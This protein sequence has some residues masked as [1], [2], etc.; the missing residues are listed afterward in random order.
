MCGTS[1]AGPGEA[2]PLLGGGLDADLGGIQPAA[3]GN[4]GPHVIDIGAELRTLGQQCGI[5]VFDPE[6][7]IPDQCGDMGE[8]ISA[9]GSGKALVG[10]REPQ[11]DVPERGRAEQGIHNGVQQDI[12]IRMAE[13]SLFKR[14]GNASE[15][16]R[17]SLDE[18]MDVVSVTYTHI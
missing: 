6:A 1:F 3:R 4:G 18:P 7:G 8:Q 13:Q 11:S 2:E 12:G 17:T 15:N 14:N 5:D 9:G 10:I 16:Q